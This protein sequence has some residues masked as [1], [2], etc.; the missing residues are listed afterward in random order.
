MLRLEEIHVSYGSS[1]VLFGISLAINEGEAVALLG[2]NGVGKTTTMRSIAGLT[3]PQRGRVLWR[4][5][6]ITGWPPHRVARLGIGFV[7]EG[8]GI[9]PDLTVRANLD[10]GRRKTEANA[11]DEERVC[12]L[13]PDLRDLMERKGG[14]LSGGQQQM[15]AIGRCLMGNPRLL[16]LDEPSEGL[17]PQIVE[18][19][20]EQIGQLK[21]E[22]L[23]IILA[24]QNL[25][26][27]LSL[28]DRLHVVEK[29][30]IQHTD[31]AAKACQ[32][33]ATIE[34]YLKL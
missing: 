31:N 24:E 32:N 33:R 2:R 12:A 27:A 15:L 7:V 3:P 34:H 25:D 1:Q 20:G 29:G 26:F 9:F 13:F 22:G 10:M 6:E 14:V 4:D 17:A 28:S 18:H 16:L 8:R 30:I 23:S 11:W 21:A 19:L 5:E